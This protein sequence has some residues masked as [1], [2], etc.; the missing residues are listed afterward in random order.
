MRELFSFDGREAKFIVMM[1]RYSR[2]RQALPCF[3]PDRSSLKLACAPLSIA[4]KNI[5]QETRSIT[6]HKQHTSVFLCTFARARMHAREHVCVYHEIGYTLPPTSLTPFL[7][8]R[9]VSSPVPDDHAAT[10]SF[11]KG[12]SSPSFLS[13]SPLL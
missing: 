4:E 9:K 5:R 6:T 3:S 8:L 12:S 13:T 2:Y 10:P 1:W 7:L 11:A